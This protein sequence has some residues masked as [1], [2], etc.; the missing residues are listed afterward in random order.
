MDLLIK[1]NIKMGDNVYLFNL[2]PVLTCTP[3]D[4]CLRGMNG[5]PRCYALRNNFLFKT[6]KKGAKVRYELSKQDNFIDLMAEEINKKEVEYFRFHSS[7]DFYN[8][9]YVRKVIAIA[10]RCPGTLFRTTTRRRDLTDVIQELDSVPNFIVRE[11]LDHERQTP[12]MG[13][14]FAALASLPVS[15]NAYNCLEDCA[16]CKYHCWH[17]REN[18]SFAES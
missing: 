7:G 1:G 2:P 6:V 3:T 13:L 4:W 5:K 8:E 14:L 10:E 15:K 18:M 11:S 17:Q 16:K 12:Q 9:S